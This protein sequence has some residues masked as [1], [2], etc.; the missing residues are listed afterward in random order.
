MIQFDEHIFQIRWNHHLYLWSKPG[1]K[2]FFGSISHDG[3][4]CADT[5]PS[6]PM[7][8]LG[9]SI[10]IVG[11]WPWWKG[12]SGSLESVIPILTFLVA[13]IYTIWKSWILQWWVESYG[14]MLRFIN[15]SGIILYGTHFCGSKNPWKCMVFVWSPGTNH[16][17]FELVIHAAP[18]KPI[19]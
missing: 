6:W 7:Y 17:F 11:C 19:H 16:A 10:E 4:F 1:F 13:G 3:Y 5:Y 9:S 8:L 2:S 18:W 12:I 15:L 14:K